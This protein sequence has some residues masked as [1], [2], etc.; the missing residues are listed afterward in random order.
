MNMSLSKLW[1]TVKYR[2]ALRATVHGVIKSLTWLNE[3]Q[4]IYKLANV[5][6]EKMRK[7]IFKFSHYGSLQWF[8]HEILLLDVET[9]AWLERVKKRG[10]YKGKAMK[11]LE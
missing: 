8:L 1:E 11:S 3:T 10:G 7:R 2:E 6:F 9:K 4:T 5:S